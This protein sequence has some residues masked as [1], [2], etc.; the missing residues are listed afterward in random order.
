[1]WWFLLVG[2]VLAL[3]AE[4]LLSNRLSSRFGAGFLQM[5]KV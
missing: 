2:A 5:K 4:A 1:V 3:I